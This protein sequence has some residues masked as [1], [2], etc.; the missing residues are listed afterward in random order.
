VLA[1][2]SKAFEERMNAFNGLEAIALAQVA[3]QSL[4][5]FLAAAAAASDDAT[6]ARNLADS[7]F[8]IRTVVENEIYKSRDT[9]KIFGTLRDALKKSAED[10]TQKKMKAE[11][12]VNQA[13]AAATAVSAV[14][15][16]KATKTLPLSIGLIT[17]IAEQ[18]MRLA[19]PL[20]KQFSDCVDEAAVQ[21]P[22]G[23]T[24]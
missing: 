8:K 13:K 15:K 3:L 1:N 12:D 2:Q 5:E 16:G 22:K 19:E 11:T 4:Q 21:A 14:S 17:S 18:T 20:Q 10:V 7:V 9:S 23:G 6:R 24:S